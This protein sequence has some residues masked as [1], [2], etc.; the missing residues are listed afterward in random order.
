MGTDNKNGEGYYSTFEPSFA[1][2]PMEV[3]VYIFRYLDQADVQA[4]GRTCLRWREATFDMEFTKKILVRFTKLCLSD[5]IPPALDYIKS[6]RPFRNYHFEEITFGGVKQIMKHIGN[7]AE[8]VIFDNVD[9]GDKQF[10][11]I[12]RQL[13]TIHSLTIT[14]C[15]QL[16]MSGSFLEN[17]DRLTLGISFAKIRHLSL[18]DN[19]Y[20]SD[21]ILLRLTEMIESIYSL[22]LSGCH[23]AYHNAIQRRFYP[24]DGR[25]VASESILTF[26]F[27]VRIL[28]MHQQHLR[29]LNLSNTLIG[30]PSLNAL[31]M[32]KSGGLRLH[33][34]G[35]AK[36]RQ[37][38]SVSLKAFLEWQT[39][40]LELNL[41]DVV[42]VDDSCLDVIV[43]N[44]S[45][46]QDLDISGCVNVSND[47]VSLLSTLK[48]L[49]CLNISRCDGIQSKGITHGI[50]STRNVILQNLQM[51]HLMVCEE[52]IKT[53]AENFPELRVLNLEQCVNGVTDESVQSI[54]KNLHWLREL[55]LV[56]CSRITDAALTGINITHLVSVPNSHSSP[57]SPGPLS[58]P[59]F[60]EGDSLNGL[61]QS[62]KISLRSKA[63]EEIVRDANRKKAMFAA[64][65]LNLIE[66]YN[67]DGYNLKKLR[68][69]RTLKLS[70]CNK[71]TDVSLKYGIK[72]LELRYLSLSNCPQISLI[73]V[74]QMVLDNPSIEILDLSDCE[75]IN[76]RAIQLIT[77]NLTR[78]RALHISGCS[79]LT[80]HSLDAISDNCKHLQT[81]SVHRCRQIY[82]DIEERF[83]N[84]TTLRNLNMDNTTNTDISILRLKKRL[85]Y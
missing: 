26:K 76:D 38:N 6:N 78:L 3:I 73:G 32:L 50:A 67:V 74:E 36:C 59:T 79:Q 5:K 7:T 18:K 56:N 69:L 42:R 54:I 48:H 27:I 68:G 39:S 84:M 77:Y 23:I 4:A 10:C 65:E 37:I 43:K 22:D 83:A 60:V 57:D 80:E 16:F 19:Q 49:K 45:L 21:A 20:L 82:T 30:A 70:G 64:Y 53:L 46:L 51:T 81:L 11:D 8:E 35:L 75:S 25:I 63:E 52:A 58:F 14:R 9:L 85:E 13:Q 41:S 34:L 33:S 40:L 72:F 31:S 47:G 66:E 24:N 15:S 2:L 55:S 61:N 28:T 29:R 1:D 17:E 44:L 71:I 62:F 12:M